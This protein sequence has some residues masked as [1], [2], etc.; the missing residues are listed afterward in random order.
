M[1]SGREKLERRFET[2]W[3]RVTST[4]RAEEVG[5]GGGAET[6]VAALLVTGWLLYDLC[7]TSRVTGTFDQERDGGRC[8]AD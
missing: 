3:R 7:A 5:G 6:F 8:I 1:R 2:G 4:A